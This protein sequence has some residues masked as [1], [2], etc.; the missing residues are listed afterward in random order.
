DG[1]HGARGLE[2][3][4]TRLRGHRSDRAIAHDRRALRGPRAVRR[5][6]LDAAPLGRGR[7][8]AESV[9]FHHQNGT[10]TSA[11]DG[12][13]HGR[14]IRPA[15]RPA[16]NAG[17]AAEAHWGIVRRGRESATIRSTKRPTM[18]LFREVYREL[19]ETG[20]D[21]L[22]LSGAGRLVSYYRRLMGF[23]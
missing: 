20:A 6:R 14:A 8:R 9:G 12:R 7:E 3:R 13:P 11:G 18:P 5:D 2:A 1:D 19:V 17:H 15:P 23:R 10:R 21:G 4:T 16:T 22:I